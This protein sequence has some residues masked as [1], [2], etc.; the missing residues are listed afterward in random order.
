MTDRMD[1]AETKK[2]WDGV[3]S[4][5]EKRHLKPTIYDHEYRGL[6]DV[7]LAMKDLASRNVWGKAVVTLDRGLQPRL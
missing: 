4:L 6:D 1:P 5:C 3:E 7:V 2:V